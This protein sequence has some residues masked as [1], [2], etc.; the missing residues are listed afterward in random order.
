MRLPTIDCGSY[1]VVE[2]TMG[3]KGS[4]YSLGSPC[5]SMR[6]AFF[7]LYQIL[8]MT[9]IACKDQYYRSMHDILGV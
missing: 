4:V 9:V 6:L 7:P 8:N 5:F 2:E 3:V 1:T